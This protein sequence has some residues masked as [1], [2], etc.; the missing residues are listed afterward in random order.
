VEI[1]NVEPAHG[2]LWIT[3]GWEIFKKSPVLWIVLSGLFAI[4]PIL[5]SNL[6]VIGE[7]LATLLVPVLMGGLMLGCQALGRGEHLMLGHLFAGFHQRSQQL[8]ALGGIGMV[9]AVL[10][11]LLMKLVGGTAL[12]E[13]LSSTQ[14]EQDP[15]AMLN[16]IADASGAWLLGGVMICVYLMASMF[17]P[18]L[19]MFDGMGPLD[20]LITSFK[21]CLKNIGP[22]FV[23][24]LVIILF[25]LLTLMTMGLGLL[26]LL[27]LSQTSAYAA[28]RDIFAVKG[29]S[30]SN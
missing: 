17:A 21:A 15:T 3:A 10:T 29:P 9:W 23:Y 1:R 14:P 18:M 28:Y 24:G 20:A 7:P 19:V 11:E 16:A 25:M 26:I 22:L 30:A 8:I 4:V 6:P 12:V 27:P 5:I 13:T 2:R